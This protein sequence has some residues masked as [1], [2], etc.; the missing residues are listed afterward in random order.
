MTPCGTYRKVGAVATPCILSSVRG[1]EKST[2]SS[3]LKVIQIHH[4]V[5]RPQKKKSTHTLK[6]VYMRCKFDIFSNCQFI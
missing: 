1:T 4:K 3:N 5:F 6:D 2:K